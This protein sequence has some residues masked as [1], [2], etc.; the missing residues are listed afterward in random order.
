LTKI[1]NP[2]IALKIS[3]LPKCDQKS[4]DLVK[5]V[6]IPRRSTSVVSRALCCRKRD[7]D[8]LENPAVDS[9]KPTMSTIGQP[10]QKG[11][12]VFVQNI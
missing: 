3:K 11:S 4:Q 12:N 5:N 10:K 7:F 6:K 2:K 9:E 1:K 8:K